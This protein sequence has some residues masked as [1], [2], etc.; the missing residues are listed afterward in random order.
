M[1]GYEDISQDLTQDDVWPIISSYFQGI[2][3]K[4]NE[5]KNC[6]PRAQQ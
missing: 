4:K 1:A 6:A 2:N 3:K 5:K